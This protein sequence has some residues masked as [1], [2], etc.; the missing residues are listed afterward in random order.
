MTAL[1]LLK[2][3]ARTH[4][5]LGPQ[6]MPKTA[7]KWG[8]VLWEVEKRG[9]V[10]KDN[11]READT[12]LLFH[13]PLLSAPGP[14]ALL[15]SFHALG[16]K[17]QIYTNGH[18]CFPLTF[19]MGWTGLGSF[20]NFR[21]RLCPTACCASGSLAVMALAKNPCQLSSSKDL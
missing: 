21:S 19:K 12:P 2:T 13:P 18:I 15:T 11:W 17:T 7:I 4:A 1:C 14:T 10:E 16:A 9:K 20:V 5:L 8:G 6:A 3:H